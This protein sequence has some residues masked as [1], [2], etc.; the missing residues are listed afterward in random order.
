MKSN[1]QPLD[2]PPDE[3]ENTT[4]ILKKKQLHKQM[5]ATPTRVKIT[6]NRYNLQ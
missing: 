3:I 1:P 2:P 6:L 5:M 4:M